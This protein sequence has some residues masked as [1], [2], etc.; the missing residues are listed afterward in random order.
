MFSENKLK[1]WRDPTVN[2]WTITR[3]MWP[4]T[5]SLQ[6]LSRW[7]PPLLTP[8]PLT[9][10]PPSHDSP[11]D[12]TPDRASLQTLPCYPLSSLVTPPPPYLHTTARG[13][14]PPDRASLQTLQYVGRAWEQAYQLCWPDIISR[15]LALPCNEYKRLSLCLALNRN[16]NKH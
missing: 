11:W 14:W 16:Q 10:P 4:L 6:T 15:W 3:G 12:V 1:V 5:P 2:Y 13:T 7:P 9:S 8:P